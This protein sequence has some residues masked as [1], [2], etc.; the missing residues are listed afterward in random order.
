MAL[1]EATLAEAHLPL[2]PAIAEASM[3]KMTEFDA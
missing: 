1:A 2:L 3:A